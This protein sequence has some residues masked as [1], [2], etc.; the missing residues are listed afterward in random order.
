MDDLGVN[1]LFSETPISPQLQHCK[2]ETLHF[3]SGHL[4]VLEMAPF[5]SLDNHWFIGSRISPSDRVLDMIFMLGPFVA[6][7]LRHVFFFNMTCAFP[8]V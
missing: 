8:K 6:Q 7:T 5:E 2:L 3:H 4:C 1:P